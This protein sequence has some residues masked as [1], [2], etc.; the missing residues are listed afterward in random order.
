MIIPQQSQSSR[1]TFRED[2]TIVRASAI[3]TSSYVLCAE[4]NDGAK[5]TNGDIYI[6]QAAQC[7]LW[8]AATF[9]GAQT[10]V[11]IQ[12]RYLDGIGGAGTFIS[13]SDGA[14]TAGS[15]VFTSAGATFL[16][17]HVGRKIKIVS[18]TNAV[19]VE[20]VIK[21]YNSAT[22]IVLDRE[23]NNGANASSV[24]F[25]ILAGEF[26]E[27]SQATSAGVTTLEPHSS[28]ILLAAG[29]GNYIYT[30][31]LPAAPIMRL[32]AK[33]GGTLTGSN[34]ILGYTLMPAGGE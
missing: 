24:V 14:Q 7:T 32:Y 3:L 1:N 9:D 13:R 31:P 8:A 28:Q 16:T 12:P 18:G 5:V 6:G 11:D 30:F 33:G 34:L 10:L 2:V 15:K 19:K 21:A 20:A 23:I 4:H 22:S 29:T 17:S 25:V 26:V 27:L